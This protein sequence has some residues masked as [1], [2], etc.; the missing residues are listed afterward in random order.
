MELR[1]K[2]DEFAT[3]QPVLVELLKRTPG[4]SSDWAADWEARD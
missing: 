1:Y 2:H 3:Q 4:I